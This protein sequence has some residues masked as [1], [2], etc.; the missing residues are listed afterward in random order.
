MTSVR[1]RP[2]DPGRRVWTSPDGV[3]PEAPVSGGPSAL[4]RLSPRTGLGPRHSR[5]GTVGTRNVVKPSKVFWTTEPDAVL[6]DD[7]QT[8]VPPSPPTPPPSSVSLAS[9]CT[10]GPLG[11]PPKSGVGLY[12]TTTTPQ[13]SRSFRPGKTFLLSPV[14][15]TQDRGG[16]QRVPTGRAGVEVGG[17]PGVRNRGWDTPE[18]AGGGVGGRGQ[19][20]C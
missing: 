17:T 4:L 14:C 6:G 18:A 11:G 20:W 13:G 19:R 7:S 16:A 2:P 1:G 3:T 9:L 15:L 5:T 12:E 8:G 10:D